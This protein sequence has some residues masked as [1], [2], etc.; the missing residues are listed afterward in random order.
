MEDQLLELEQLHRQL[1]LLEKATTT[2][3]DLVGASSTQSTTASDPGGLSRDPQD[4]PRGLPLP[5]RLEQAVAAASIVSAELQ[6]MHRQLVTSGLLLQQEE[7]R[8][9]QLQADLVRAKVCYAGSCYAGLCWAGV[10]LGWAALSWVELAGLFSAVLTH[11]LGRFV[12][13]YFHL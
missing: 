5:E 6:S 12:Y 10:G 11:Q 13:S 4:D 9:A 3:E 1:P 7:A 2:L 8:A